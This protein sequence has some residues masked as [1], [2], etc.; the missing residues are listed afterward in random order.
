M[1]KDKESNEINI[2]EETTADESNQHENNE[3]EA[4][5]AEVGKLKDALLRSEADKENL[6]KRLSRELEDMAKYAIKNF[7]SDLLEVLENLY[8]AEEAVDKSALEQNSQ[9][10]VF[11]DGVVMTRNSLID[12]FNK[13]GIKRIYPINEKF[14]HQLHQAISYAYSGEH[15]AG[16]VM[17]VVQAGYELNGRLL[18]PAMVIVSAEPK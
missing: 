18:R 5:Q 7:A 10:K 9:L 2:M 17:T 15:E 6:R 3:L 12:V 16:I 14:D 11:I 4:L 1:L 13:Q 8:R